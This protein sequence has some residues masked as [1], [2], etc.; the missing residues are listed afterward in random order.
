MTDEKYWDWTSVAGTSETASELD[1]F[2][3]PGRDALCNFVIAG[4]FVDGLY[5]KAILI[6][7]CKPLIIIYI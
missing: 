5:F 2:L 6:I 1:Y 4:T 3:N 7:P